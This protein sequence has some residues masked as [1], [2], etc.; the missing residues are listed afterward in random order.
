V[1]GVDKLGLMND[2]DLSL[3]IG[4]AFYAAFN[5]FVGDSARLE[6]LGKAWK[7]IAVVLGTGAVTGMAAKSPLGTAIANKLHHIFGRVE[8]NLEPLVV[9]FGS[10]EA[11]FGAVETATK[12]AVRQQGLTGVFKTTVTVNGHN[13][14]VRGN[15]IDGVP[16]IG[17]FFMAP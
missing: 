14:V 10:E 15:V 1:G 13:V 8:H 12:A 7:N 3:G 2:M 17:T 9:Q 4:P 5:P 11:A 6:A 16:R